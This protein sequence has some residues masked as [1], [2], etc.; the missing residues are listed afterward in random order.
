MLVKAIHR[1]IKLTKQKRHTGSGSASNTAALA[2]VWWRLRMLYCSTTQAR[3]D[4]SRCHGIYFNPLSG[5]QEAQ[6]GIPA[7][8]QV[9]QA[10][11]LQKAQADYNR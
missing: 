1:A 7:T 3:G 2:P 10:E 6:A 4:V 11:N 8:Q 5:S 9:A